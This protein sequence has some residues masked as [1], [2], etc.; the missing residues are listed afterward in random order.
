MQPTG[1]QRIKATVTG[2]RQCRPAV[3]KPDRHER[4]THAAPLDTDLRRL[5]NRFTCARE[6]IAQNFWGASL[7]VA[8]DALDEN[9][10][11][12]LGSAPTREVP[13]KPV[14]YDEQ[15]EILLECV[16]VLVRCVLAPGVGTRAR[17]E[18]NASIAFELILALRIGRRASGLERSRAMI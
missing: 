3:A 15:P 17:R 1:R 11:A 6:R 12:V 4:V 8:T 16:E 14:G 7:R 18:F 5:E 13:A 10:N 9:S 2:L